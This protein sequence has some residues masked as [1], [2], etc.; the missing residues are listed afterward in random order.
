VAVILII[1]D[2]AA[3]LELARYLL[4]H[5]GHEVVAA[6]DGS[7]GVEL[8]A[9]ARPELVVCDLQIPVFD[10]FEVLRRLRQLPECRG[11]PVIAVTAFSMAGDEQR[12]LQA[13][14]DG[15]ISKPIEPEEFSARIGAFLTRS[16][17]GER[18]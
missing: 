3:S 7:R 14:F 18:P 4:V 12:V 8:A 1:E 13:G 11:V 17:P 16:P 5:A 2:N 15:Y 9:T 6:T 10:G